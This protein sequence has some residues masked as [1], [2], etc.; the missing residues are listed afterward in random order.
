MKSAVPPVE[1]AIDYTNLVATARAHAAHRRT[2]PLTFFGKY[3]GGDAKAM[4]LCLRE[5]NEM[6]PSKVI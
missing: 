5:F 6:A 2:L 4:F 1:G 3:L